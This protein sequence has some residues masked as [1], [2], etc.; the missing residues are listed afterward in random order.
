MGKL[1][2]KGLIMVNLVGRKAPN[3]DASAVLSNGEISE[4]YNLYDH[5]EGKYGLLF[6]FPF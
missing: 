2:K 1:I 5:I 6:F 4:N 3:F